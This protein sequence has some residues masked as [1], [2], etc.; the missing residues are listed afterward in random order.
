MGLINEKIKQFREQKNL[1]IEELAERSGVNTNVLSAIE[2]GNEAPSSE[3]RRMVWRALGLRV[4]TLLEVSNVTGPVLTKAGE[5]HTSTNFSNG[6]T[7]HPDYANYSSDLCG[8]SSTKMK[9]YCTKTN[10][11]T[12]D[13][14]TVLESADDA[15][16]SSAAR[17]GGRPAQD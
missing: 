2:N 3:N 4:D 15:A 11:G 9:K 16:A 7:S 14:K 10:Y 13:N 6:K 1:S 12:V 5:V 8:G 17:P